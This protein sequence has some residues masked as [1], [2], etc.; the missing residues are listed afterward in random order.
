MERINRNL[1]IFLFI[2]LINFSKINNCINFSDYDFA[3][4]SHFKQSISYYNLREN[5]KK[6]G[7]EYIKSSGFSP[8][9]IPNKL[10]PEYELKI[11]DTIEELKKE[12]NHR[13]DN[14]ISYN[15]VKSATA[16]N[17]TKFHKKLT[18]IVLNY[19]LDIKVEA[20]INQ[21]VNTY[22]I[23]YSKY[24]HRKDKI[25]QKLRKRMAQDGR[26]YIR[27]SEIKKEV[28]DE[29]NYYSTQHSSFSWDNFFTT[30]FHDPYYEQTTYEPAPTTHFSTKIRS[31]EF[32]NKILQVAEKLLGRKHEK[33]PARVISN[34]SEKVQK[35]KTR[36]NGMITYYKDYVEPD[37]IERI[38]RQ[39][40]QSVLDKICYK[41]EIC[42]ICQ[43]DFKVGQRV[44]IVSC[45]GG[46]IYHKDCI[47]QWLNVD[48]KKSCPMC[49]QE[50]II[51]A[52]MEDVPYPKYL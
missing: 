36:L 11:D 2:I 51:V 12:L 16:K 28:R 22:S 3:P 47:Y 27:R 21:L 50:N 14:C 9:T 19:D 31:H 46:H 38:A 44:G 8:Y 4:P 15:E 26:N 41:G 45:N 30:I 32:D 18:K 48:A 13:W 7:S 24:H 52:K 33:I 25:L 49:R 40:L 10:L 42:P 20:I 29:F 6:A 37:D 39:E 34:Y 35:I 23:P 43:D 1:V 17:L 5:V